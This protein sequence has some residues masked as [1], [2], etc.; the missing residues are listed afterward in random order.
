MEMR[1]EV[2]SDVVAQDMVTSGYQASDLDLFEFYWENDQLVVEA[3]SRQKIG[4]P[5]PPTALDDL[6]MA[7]SAENPILLVNEEDKEYSPQT[8]LISQ[9]PTRPPTLL[10]SQ[11]FGA[12]INNVLEYL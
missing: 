1:D 5:V 6:E 2:L 9:R 4:T 8:I 7:G 12:R 3:A 11:P 10:R